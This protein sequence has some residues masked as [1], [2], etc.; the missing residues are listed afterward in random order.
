[1]LLICPSKEEMEYVSHRFKLFGCNVL[2]RKI[3]RMK[4]TIFS[5]NIEQHQKNMLV[6]SIIEI[7]KRLDMEMSKFQYEVSERGLDVEFG[8]RG[9]WRGNSSNDVYYTRWVKFLQ[10]DPSADMGKLASFMT[11]SSYQM[12]ERLEIYLGQIED[13]ASYMMLKSITLFHDD[14]ECTMIVNRD[15]ERVSEPEIRM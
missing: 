5:R 7:L 1:V 8:F 2:R 14:N 6:N 3:G 10:V 11:N 13:L 15:F 9:A 4:L 12:R